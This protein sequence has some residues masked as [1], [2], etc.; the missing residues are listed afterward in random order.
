MEYRNSK[1]LFHYRR[2]WST[3][4]ADLNEL[5]F[6]IWPQFPDSSF[7]S[8]KNVFMHRIQKFPSLGAS[9]DQGRTT[10]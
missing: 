2:Q 1:N 8:W 5:T 10:S 7:M 3:A 6:D 9:W 4:S